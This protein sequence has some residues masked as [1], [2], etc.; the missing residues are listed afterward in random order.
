MKNI[1]FLL[2]I[3]VIFINIPFALAE[4]AEIRD[5]YF[6]T[7]KEA[8]L[9]DSFGD[10]RTAHFHEGADIMGKQMMPLYAA[11]DGR[12]KS[13][14]IPEASWGYAITI[15]DSDGYTYHY[16]HI[17]NDT[18]GTD[19]ANGGVSNAYAPGIE[20]GKIVRKGDLIGWMGD[21]GNAENVGPHLHF[22]IRRPD[23]TPIDP[24]ASLLAALNPKP[25]FDI[26]AAMAAS[27]SINDDKNLEKSLDS[28][29][30]SGSLIKLLGNDAVYYCGANGK[31]YAFP[32]EK[33][34][35]TWYENF[36]KVLEIEAE[37][38][39]KIPLG[40]NVNYRP[41]ARMLKLQSSP[42]VYAVDKGAVLRWVV[43][44]EIAESLYGIDWRE[45]IDDLPDSLFF[46]YTIGNNIE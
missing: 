17:N 2:I 42:K 24:Y 44:G 40:G 18:P 32:N 16:L 3:A 23:K 14:E 9:T 34:Y 13:L 28:Y 15:V 39:S 22:E 38:M 27:P 31:R 5:I 19:D 20:R 29:C 37:E 12:V 8:A 1:Y 26:E 10:P 45:K 21:S 33:I 25:N 7:S 30:Q 41:G 11:V 46:N 36:E 43:S 35:F 4:E 6:P